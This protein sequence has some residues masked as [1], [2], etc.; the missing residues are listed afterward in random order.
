M[1]G[2]VVGIK[3]KR[4]LEFGPATGGIP[5]ERHLEAAE[6]GVGMGQSGIEAKSLADFG[7]K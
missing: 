1:G 7:P 4:F 5:I 6:D 3:R 2:G